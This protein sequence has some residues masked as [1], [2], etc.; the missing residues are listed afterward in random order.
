MNNNKIQGYGS[1]R[2]SAD[3]YRIGPLYADNIEVASEI[4]RYLVGCVP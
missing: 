3:G 1:I 2:L 4:Y